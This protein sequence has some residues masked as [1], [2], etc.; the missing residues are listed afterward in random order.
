MYTAWSSWHHEGTG[1]GPGLW[2]PGSHPPR[3]GQHPIP[4][5]WVYYDRVRDDNKLKDDDH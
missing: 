1:S 3:S 4:D 5:G 2:R